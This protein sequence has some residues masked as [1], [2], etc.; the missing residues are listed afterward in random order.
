M[1]TNTE[2]VILFKIEKLIKNL[3]FCLYY[4]LI[5]NEKYFFVICTK[6]KL[7]YI[8]SSNDFTVRFA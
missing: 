4:G 6:K 8:T 7:F 2:K 1:K 3:S 5:Y